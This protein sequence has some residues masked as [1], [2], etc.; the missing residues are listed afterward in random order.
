MRYVIIGGVAAGMS[1]AAKIA[2]SAQ[3][4]QV[5]VY[6]AGDHVSYGACGLP[7]YI[8]GENPEE[9]KL[10]ARSPQQLREQGIEVL[11]RHRVTRVAPEDR[12]I[13]ARSLDTGDM[14]IDS[15]DRLLIATGASAIVPDLPGVRLEGVHTLKTL[16]DANRIRGELSGASTV[17]IAGG[18]Y[19]GIELCEA[20]VH[21]GKQVVLIEAEQHILSGF[22]PEL[23]AMAEEELTRGGVALR[24]GERL[25]F[26]E[27][28]EHVRAVG[29]DAGSVPCDMAI[30]A[31]GVRP[32]TGFLQGSGIH[33]AP[34]GAV[35]ADRELRASQPDV[36]AAGDC[37]TVYH[38]VA[39]EQAYI[40]L[41]TVANKCGRLAGGNMTG[42]RDKF[43]G[44]LGSAAIKV[45]GLEFARTGLSER[46]AG[47]LG[48]DYGVAAVTVPD[49]A[50]YYPDPTP[51][52]MQLL[53]DNDTG[54]VLGGCAGGAKGAVLRVDALAAAITGGLT[55]RQL[56]QADFCYAPP[57]AGVWDVLNIAA[58]NAERGRRSRG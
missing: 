2:R 28:E 5:T 16:E 18:G 21:L 19:I 41:G 38:R 34:N 8:S 51:V 36:W 12:R 14:A 56:G 42:R 25:R 29:T 39:M 15:Y 49:H 50:R 55:L 33:L 4:A 22:A 52:V 11:T 37:A 20:M 43:E 26:L 9:S 53:Y 24:L 47:D 46:E 3:G 13:M 32:N 7:Y 48:L 6:E 54:R 44:A 27:G 45:L 17:A 1:A 58:N 57:F 10:F 30:L 23:S 35:E 31:L 40:P